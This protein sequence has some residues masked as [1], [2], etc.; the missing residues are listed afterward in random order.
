ML[1]RSLRVFRMSGSLTLSAPGPS[2]TQT[3]PT[4]AEALASPLL[5]SMMIFALYA[6]PVVV[7]VRP[8]G[9]PVLD[10]DV[11]WH[12][13]VGQ[14][15][16]EHRAVPVNDPFSLP[17]QTQP[18]AAYS[19]L[20]ELLLY[21]LYSAFGLAGVVVYR[22]GMALA[23]VA[24]IHAL[25]CRL[26]KRFLVAVGL[27]AA[28]VLAVAMLF[29][30][31]PWL[32]TILFTTLTLN[33]I[34]SLR[35]PGT[36]P[37]WVWRFPVVFVLW[38]C[39]HIQFVYGLF[40][41]A[42]ACVAPLID[43]RFGRPPDDTA[44][45]AWSRQWVRL[46][47]LSAACF[48]ATLINPYHVRLYGVVIEYATQPGPFRFINEL[49][50]LEFREP[51]DWVMLALTGTACW[52]LGRRKT[53]SAFDVLLLIST[54]CFAFRARRDLW[55]VVL[56]DLVVLASAGPSLV[57]DGETFRLSAPRL[58]GVGLAL[59]VLAGICAWARICLPRACSAGWP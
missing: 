3:A 42:L 15:V 45:S 9:V 16:A 19:F 41:L 17:G 46:V 34:L 14:W 2:S 50:A 26:E 32:F 10:P 31:R 33:A 21:T 55:F 57:P 20:Y 49:K 47:M 8:V 38:A 23:V 30:E 22:A 48:L 39:I 56:A 5:R 53:T 7:A 35:Q 25:V 18:W 11:W 40:L 58:A 13:R 37:R 36:P 6:I 54:A 24:A 28:A 59:A 43:Q 1:R 51:C 4:P 12:L 29:S 52:A 27:T 44:A